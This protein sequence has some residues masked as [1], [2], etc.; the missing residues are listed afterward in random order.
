MY[1]VVGL[2][3]QGPPCHAVSANIPHEQPNSSLNTL[4]FLRHLPAL[5]YVPTFGTLIIILPY[6]T[7]ASLWYYLW[8]MDSIRPNPRSMRYQSQA[9]YLASHKCRRYN[10]VWDYHLAAAPGSTMTQ[11][12]LTLFTARLSCIY[13]VVDSAWRM[14]SPPI[15]G[16]RTNPVP[17]RN[18]PSASGSGCCAGVERYYFQLPCPG[19]MPRTNRSVRAISS[20][21]LHEAWF[22]SGCQ[23]HV[24]FV[25]G[26][27]SRPLS[28]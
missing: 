16:K 26:I 28:S 27:K 22:I 18:T 17:I 15:R 11:R 6:S 8:D 14:I 21:G 12:H 19:N 4:A 5:R 10:R 7:S 23:S 3:L 13:A 24:L 9:L 1:L 20:V 2:F 25:T